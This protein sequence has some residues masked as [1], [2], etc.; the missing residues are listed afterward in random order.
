M[1][2]TEITVERGVHCIKH[3]NLTN[4][5]QMFH[6]FYLLLLS[7]RISFLQNEMH[8]WCLLIFV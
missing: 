3:G 1:T 2:A 4:W 6:R 5:I 7:E 8:E